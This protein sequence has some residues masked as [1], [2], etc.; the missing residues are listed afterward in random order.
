MFPGDS[1]IHGAL[2]GTR[3]QVILCLLVPDTIAAI[4]PEPESHPR[5]IRSKAV[6][7]YLDCINKMKPCSAE[8]K[9]I[10]NSFS[11]HRKAL[12]CFFSALNPICA[13]LP[14]S[15]SHFIFI[16]QSILPFF[17][18]NITQHKFSL[19]VQKRAIQFIGA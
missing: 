3:E 8:A 11:S 6:S 10:E 16:L 5:T 7:F 15:G 19:C 18:C 13:I 9:V 1:L 4:S 17:L 12:L 2:S 14:N